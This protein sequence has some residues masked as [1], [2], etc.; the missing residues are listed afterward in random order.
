MFLSDHQIMKR[1]EG[2]EP[3]ISSFVA[4][5]I[6]KDK[7]EHPVTHSLAFSYNK[8]I[9]Y[10]LSS[11]GYD[12]RLDTTFLSPRFSIESNPVVDPKNTKVTDY[13]EVVRDVIDIPP[14]SFVLGKTVEYFR[15]PRDILALC[16]G[17]ST[18]ARCGI[19][20]NV[21]PLE[22]EWRGHVT[23]EI[24]NMNVKPVRVYA[25]EG[26]A[27]FLFAWCDPFGCIGYPLEANWHTVANECQ[28][29]YADRRGKY[30]DQREVTVARL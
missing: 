23:I 24:S 25:G 14:H 26:I 12:A 8:Q 18:Y 22:P 30:Q 15:I 21:T 6:S 2:D 29:S 28:T 7:R 13:E 27:Q 20:V 16:V 17:K 10:G 11:Y 1:C 9:S 3:M 4:E 5:Q 19:N